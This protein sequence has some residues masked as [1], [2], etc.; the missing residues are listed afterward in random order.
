MLNAIKKYLNRYQYDSYQKG[1]ADLPLHIRY[2]PRMMNKPTKR[3]RNHRCPPQHLVHLLGTRWTMPILHELALHDGEGFNALLRR[4]KLISPKMLSYRL[5]GL[6]QSGIVHRTV[7]QN[8]LPARVSYHLTE[9]G[10]ELRNMLIKIVSWYSP[11]DQ[12]C[13]ERSCTECPR[14]EQTSC[15]VLGKK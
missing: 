11:Q 10:V 3:I 13:G 5:Q 1:S 12:H 7:H 15:S 8:M 4:M 9:Q 2:P 14:F 6:E